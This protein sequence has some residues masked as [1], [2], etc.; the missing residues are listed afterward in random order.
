MNNNKNEAVLIGYKILFDR[1]GNL[2]TERIS[3][4]IKKL[5][6]YFS[7]EDYSM[8]RSIINEATIKLDKIHNEIEAALNARK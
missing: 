7:Q 5:K 8:V 6:K 2:I 4:D 1:K 3:T